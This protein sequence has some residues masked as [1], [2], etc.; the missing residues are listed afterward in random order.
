VA[1]ISHVAV[2]ALSACALTMRAAVVASDVVVL[3]GDFPI[4]PET[5]QL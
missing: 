1:E 4:R 3:K 2:R 5:E